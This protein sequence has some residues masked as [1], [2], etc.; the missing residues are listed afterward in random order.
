[1]WHLWSSPYGA[2]PLITGTATEFHS[3][4]MACDEWRWEGMCVLGGVG[5][6]CGG[7]IIIMPPLH[8][9]L[10]SLHTHTRNHRR[11]DK[12]FTSLRNFIYSVDIRLWL[13]TMKKEKEMPC[14]AYANSTLGIYHVEAKGTGSVSASCQPGTR[15][16][17]WQGWYVRKPLFY[18]A[19]SR[20]LSCPHLFFSFFF[21]L[22]DHLFLFCY[23]VLSFFYGNQVVRG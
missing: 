23:H 22:L 3:L 6:A 14:I 21:F 9:T 10:P 11:C 13:K 2:L 5:G 15:A 7:I 20:S 17:F 19:I 8:P 16:Q 1:M 18:F 4:N 12:N